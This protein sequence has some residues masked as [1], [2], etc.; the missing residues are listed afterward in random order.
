MSGRVSAKEIKVL[1]M[2][3]A[4]GLQATAL[5]NVLVNVMA[6]SPSTAMEAASADMK[7]LTSKLTVPE[8][9]PSA[10]NC[11]EVLVTTALRGRRVRSKQAV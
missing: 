9:V 6:S 10:V 7:A 1:T 4:G 8:E 11:T 3:Q 2:V 5:E